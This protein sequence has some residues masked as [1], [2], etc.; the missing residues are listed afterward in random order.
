MLGLA[1]ANHL[2]KKLVE[3]LLCARLWEYGGGTDL[4]WI[5]WHSQTLHPGSA[6]PT[7]QGERKHALCGGVSN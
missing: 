4:V 7:A 1:V 6:G 3:H 2:L 5:S